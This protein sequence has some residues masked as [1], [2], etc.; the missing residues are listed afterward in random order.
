MSAAGL[1]VAVAPGGPNFN[2]AWIVK[3]IKELVV[4]AVLA[5]GLIMLWRA[6]GGNHHDATKHSGLMLLGLVWVGI[7][8]TTGGA[9]AL[10]VY[11]AQQ[12]GLL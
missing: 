3:L 6:K 11:F 8:L 4:I 10:G 5:G 2:L 12:F 9:V 7:A 1:L